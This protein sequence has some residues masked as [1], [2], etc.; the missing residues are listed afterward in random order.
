MPLFR[1]FDF[2]G[3]LDISNSPNICIESSYFINDTSMGLSKKIFSGNAGAVA[4]GYNDTGHLHDIKPQIIIR[5]CSFIN[6]AARVS[7]NFITVIEVLLKHVYNQRGGGMAFYFGEN[8]Y[9]GTITIEQCEFSNNT[10][11]DSGGG[12]YMFLSGR[13]SFQTIMVINTSFI[14]NTAQYGGGLE[15][16][17]F[18]QDSLLTPNNITVIFCVFEENFGISGGGYNN[19]QLNH[20]AN[21]NHLY[22]RATIFHNN[23]ADV[24]AG[25]YMQSAVTVT[26]VTLPKRIFVENW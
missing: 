25:L 23:I 11:E 15:T 7:D 9:N 20:L 26:N 16:T 21:F 19:I 18:N 3:A 1:N 2:G 12:I 17:H 22:V 5:G 6:N 10:A 14:G 8:E 24:G 4:I 13:N